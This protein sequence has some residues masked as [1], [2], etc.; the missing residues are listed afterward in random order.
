M[1]DS[2]ANFGPR[3]AYTEVHDF[4]HNGRNKI[5]KFFLQETILVRCQSHTGAALTNFWLSF[6]LSNLFFVPV[7][8]LMFESALGCGGWSQA[9]LIIVTDATD[10]VSVNFFWPV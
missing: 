8:H 10:G 6:G 2:H 4:R 5:V 1:F 3:A 7:L 9:Y